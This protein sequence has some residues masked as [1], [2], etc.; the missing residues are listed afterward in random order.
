[1]K[2]LCVLAL[3][4]VSACGGGGNASPL[5]AAPTI[6]P[7]ATPSIA[8][9]TLA[10][11]KFPLR[12]LIDMQDISWH[13]TDA[14]R[15]VFDITNV[16]GFPGVFGGIVI[17]ATWAQMQS[18]A[19]AAV[20]FSLVDSALALVRTYNTSNQSSPIGVKLR[21]Y[22]GNS[23][24]QWAKDLPGGP[25]TIYRNP[26]GCNGLTDT[27]PLTVGPFWTQMYIADW[28]AFQALV[29][30][31]Y[32][33]EPLIRA[34]AVTSCASQTDEPFVPT[35]GPIGKANLGAAGY[36]DTVEEACLTGAT[37]DYAAW[38]NTEIDFTFNEY[39]KFT[40]GLDAAFTE[41]VMALCRQ[42]AAV[43]C[44]LDNHALQT[45]LTSDLPIYAAI[46]AAGGLI[47]FQT[48]SPEGMGCLWPE[49]ITQGLL[50]GAR[51]VEVWP[52]AKYQ[53]F[54]TLTVP[55]VTALQALFFAPLPATTPVP[56]PL[57]TPCTGY[58]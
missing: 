7:S 3:I 8:P 37:T 48:Q 27:C 23:A 49:T 45:P 2:Y 17:N 1:M 22:G 12:G 42:Q 14:G 53:G 40:G 31:K 41:S 16:E 54:D 39:S 26:A 52:E 56:S 47:N 46:A 21:I 38:K 15:P 33:G 35:S 25:I 28:R 57:P 55:E 10:E 9:V 24:P 44:V 34:V 18:T 19:G 4:G 30:A 50:L 11:P 13:N 43:G 5:I 58:N 29:A 20:D 6:A 36:N 32:D 51:A